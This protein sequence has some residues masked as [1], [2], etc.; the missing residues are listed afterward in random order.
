[1]DFFFTYFYTP[2]PAKRTLA[3]AEAA[4]A[5]LYWTLAPLFHLHSTGVTLTEAML[6][7]ATKP[8]WPQLTIFDCASHQQ[9]TFDSCSF[10]DE[11][12]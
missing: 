5:K 9:P 12:E 8:R 4:P 6:S 3:E 11:D 7:S 2:L 10:C 1:M